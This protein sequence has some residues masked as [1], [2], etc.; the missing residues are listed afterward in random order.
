MTGWIVGTGVPDCPPA[1]TIFTARRYVCRGQSRTPVP[2]T[3]CI[4]FAYLRIKFCFGSRADVREHAVLP[5]EINEIF[6]QTRRGALC[7][8][9]YQNDSEK[10][11]IPRFCR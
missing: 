4:F 3:T 9:A 1:E 10:S 11:G 8:P 2:T 7:A 6:S 5:Y